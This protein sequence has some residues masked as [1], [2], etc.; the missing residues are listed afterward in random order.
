MPVYLLRAG[1]TDK[2]KIGYA[3]DV[4]D[5]IRSLQSAHWERLMLLRTW[6]GGTATEAWL[7]GRFSD[8]RIARDWF[9]FDPAMLTV[10]PPPLSGYVASGR[11]GNSKGRVEISAVFGGQT[12]LGRAIGVGQGTVS[13]WFITGIFPYDRIVQIIA[14]AERLDPPVVLKPNDFFPASLAL[15]AA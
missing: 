1:E 2:A 13:R 10:E 6:D 8:Y 12:R 5:R 15:A 14:A 9:V 7:H 3:K 11:R 4:S